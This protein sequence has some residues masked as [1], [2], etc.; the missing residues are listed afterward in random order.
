MTDAG[1]GIAR[2]DRGFPRWRRL[3]TVLAALLIL[4]PAALAGVFS[5]EAPLA[6]V[7]R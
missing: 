3:A 2:A 4:L 7:T 5:D 1:A 6:T